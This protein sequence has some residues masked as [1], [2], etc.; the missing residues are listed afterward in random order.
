[1]RDH[2]DP[3]VDEAMQ[4][5]TLLRGNLPAAA[6]MLFPQPETKLDR[7]PAAL[8][9]DPGP[10]HGTQQEMAF[11][12]DPCPAC[13]MAYVPQHLNSVLKLLGP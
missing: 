9:L 12:G 8:L 3:G 1:M 5:Y 10:P 4:I 11:T 13:G 2:P 7:Y 6:P